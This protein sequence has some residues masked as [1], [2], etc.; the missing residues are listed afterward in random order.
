MTSPQRDTV[1][2]LPVVEGDDKLC[3]RQVDVYMIQ[4]FMVPDTGL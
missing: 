2:A 1:Q 4:A 3:F